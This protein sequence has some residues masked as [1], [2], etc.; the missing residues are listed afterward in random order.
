MREAYDPEI[1]WTSS[2][3]QKAGL[4]PFTGDEIEASTFTIADQN[5]SLALSHML[6]RKVHSHHI[7]N[8][9]LRAP[10]YHIEVITTEGDI[11]S[12]FVLEPFQV[13]KVSFRRHLCLYYCFSL[14]A[15]LV[16]A[17]ANRCS[18]LEVPPDSK[19]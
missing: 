13:Q 18:G 3:R 14:S 19:A 2:L 15:I 16:A 9:N 1:H 4:S 10:V 12:K 17:I 5:G 8:Q 11:M 7:L 6:T